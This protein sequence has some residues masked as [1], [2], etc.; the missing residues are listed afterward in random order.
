M[1]EQWQTLIVRQKQLLERIERLEKIKNGDEKL[2]GSEFQ[3]THFVKIH[4]Y[5][6]HGYRVEGGKVMGELVNGNEIKHP[7]KTIQLHFSSKVA[8][9]DDAKLPRCQAESNIKWD[10]GQNESVKWARVVVY[11]PENDDGN[12]WCCRIPRAC[13]EPIV[14]S[15]KVRT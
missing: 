9:L 3:C 10:T 2:R 1:V 15:P 6:T 13:L 11:S 4:G 5:L 12:F 8:L 7:S 14:W